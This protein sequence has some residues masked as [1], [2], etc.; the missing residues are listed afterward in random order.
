MKYTMVCK[1]D[2]VSLAVS[3]QIQMDL[4]DTDFIYDEKDFEL[5]LVVGGDGTF[6]YAVN[7]CLDRL[8][9]V[10]FYG[11]HTGTLGFY[12]DYDRSEYDEFITKLKNHDFKEVSFPLLQAI[13]DGKNYFGINEIRIE[14]VRRTQKMDIYVDDHFFEELRSSG[15]C[16]SSQWGSTALNRSLGGAVVQEGLNI[17]QMCEI[18]GI[19]HSKYRSLNS[20]VIMKDS[21]YLRFESDDFDGAILGVDQNIY[22][23][24][25]AKKVE[26]FLC[27]C[28]KVRVLRG[29]NVN[30]FTRLQS[31]F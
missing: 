9:Q 27:K 21:S 6:L 1:Q 19:H 18:A 23:I 17:I 7:Q 2:D 25:D 22:D 12:T 29:K 24:K 30:Y 13:V 14:N 11:I 8:D 15:V 10:Y 5:V 4:Q 26:I 20:S 31:L 3:K 16:V 28:H